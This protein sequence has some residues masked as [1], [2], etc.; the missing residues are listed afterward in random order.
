MSATELP[1]INVP[2]QRR[3]PLV[4][5]HPTAATPDMLRRTQHPSRD[6]VPHATSHVESVAGASVPSHRRNANSHAAAVRD[7]SPSLGQGAT[8][9]R[10]SSAA[11]RTLLP[12]ASSS[13]I[14]RGAAL[15][16]NLDS[17]D[18]HLPRAIHSATASGGLK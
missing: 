12:P 16:A 7:G 14:S 9:I 4:S 8:A 17:P 10:H 18:G 3:D 13:A 2:A 5:D 1:A 11:E 6:H 15:A